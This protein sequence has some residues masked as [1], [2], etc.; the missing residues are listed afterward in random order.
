MKADHTFAGMIARWR[1]KARWNRAEIDKLPDDDW[2]G[3]KAIHLRGV[4]ARQD[5][6]ADEGQA[7]LDRLRGL[8]ELMRE[9]DDWGNS[10][11][12][13]NALEQ[14]LGPKQASE[15]TSR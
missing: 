1:S 9:R 2:K 5:E 4:A 11:A 10:K 13:A 6:C 3:V 15:R 14:L 8:T 12:W 7:M